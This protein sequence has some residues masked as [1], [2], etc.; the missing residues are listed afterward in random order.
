VTALSIRQTLALVILFVAI[1]VTLIALDNRHTLDPLKSGLHAVV[2]PV[3]QWIDDLVGGDDELSTVEVQLEQVR[4]ERDQLLS[5][6][7]QLKMQLEDV[8]RLRDVLN[9]QETNPGQQLLAAN[10]INMDPAGL[11]K[12]VTIDRGSR[13]GVEVGMA[14]IDPYYFVGLVTEVEERSAKVTL[15]IDATSAV[16]ARTL[17]SSGIGVSYGMWQYGGR[18]E[19]RHVDRE[20]AP[21]EGEVVVTSDETEAR[22]ARVPGGLIIGR[23]TGEPELDNQSDAQIIQVLPAADFD[24]LSIVAVIL[25]DEDIDA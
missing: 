18:I 21:E 3:V 4:E 12:F 25:S 19:L 14:V 10:V 1:A 2:S 8:E 9:V 16:G 23:V 5:E 22:T 20:I 17:D 24:H 13:D 6:N 11:Q 7:A 15:A